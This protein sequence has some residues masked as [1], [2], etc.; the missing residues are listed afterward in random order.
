MSISQGA[1]VQEQ[2]ED[3]ASPSLA[4]IA[5]AMKVLQPEPKKGSI[6]ANIATIM[7]AAVIGIGAW[8][9]TGLS[10]MQTTVTQVSATVVGMSKVVDQMAADIKAGDSTQ[11]Q[12]KQDVARLQ[13]RVDQNEQRLTALDGRGNNGNGAGPA[14]GVETRP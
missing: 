10:S 5:A 3:M 11:S 2:K 4:D 6:E 7:T 12:I 14:R 1:G 9:L 13:Q 8:L